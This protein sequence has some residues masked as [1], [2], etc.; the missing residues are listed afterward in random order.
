LEVNS[1]KRFLTVSVLGFF[2]RYSNFSTFL[3]RFIS[4]LILWFCP[5]YGKK[6]QSCIFVNY[7]AY[8][9]SVEFSY[10]LFFFCYICSFLVNY[11]QHW[12]NQVQFF[13]LSYW[14]IIN[15]IEKASCL[16]NSGHKCIRVVPL[17]FLC[18]V[19]M[20]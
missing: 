6:T 11:K 3:K 4:C 10:S 20:S 7:P 1:S 9:H 5:T 18:S 8:L 17:L 19:G 2:M 14:Q 12:F 16:D 15:S 13:F